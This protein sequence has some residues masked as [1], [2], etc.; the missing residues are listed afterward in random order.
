MYTCKDNLMPLLYSGKKINQKKKKKKKGLRDIGA[1]PGC[2]GLAVAL[3]QI[4]ISLLDWRF[5]ELGDAC[6]Y[7]GSVHNRL[8]TQNSSEPQVLGLSNGNKNIFPAYLSQLLCRSN[9]HMRKYFVNNRVLYIFPC[10]VG[11][12]I[13]CWK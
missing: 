11:H 6:A 8:L 9:E 13:F 12:N 3:G 4:S 5:L 2:Q 7:P 1:C 10:D